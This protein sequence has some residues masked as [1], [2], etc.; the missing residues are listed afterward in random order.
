MK[1]LFAG[2]GERGLACLEALAG[3]GYEL[4]GVLAPPGEAGGGL[5]A[6]ARQLRRPCFQPADCNDPAAVAALAALRPEVT[7]LAGYAQIVQ[8][9]L[10]ELAPQGCL[11]L[12]AGKLPAYRGSSPLNWALINGETEFTLSV[13]QVDLGVDTGDV[14]VEQTF[15]IGPDETIAD[16]HRTA[17]RAFPELLTEALQGLAAGTLV[18]RPQGER[19]ARYFPLRFPEDGLVLWDGLAA[20]QIHDRI[21]AL[22]RPYPG[23]FTYHRGRQVRLWRSRLARGTWKGEPGRVYRKSG[24]ALLVCARDGCLWVEEASFVEGP[25]RVWDIVDRYDRFLTLG[26]AA[27]AWAVAQRPGR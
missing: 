9:P 24:Q 8:P 17:N 7:V 12:H 21:R 6:R 5:A 3:A 23:A 14:L 13:I 4:C 16:L 26:Q 18:P 1:V 2:K 27:E 10:I 19:G 25:D 22:T 11:N 20:V 15:P